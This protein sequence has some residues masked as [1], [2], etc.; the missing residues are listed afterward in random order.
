MVAPRPT[1]KVL[2]DLKTTIMRPALTSHFQ[3]W[4]NPPEAMRTWARTHRI[5][6]G[7]GDG[8]DSPQSAEFFSLSCAEAT[9]PGSSLATHEINNDFTGVTERH[10]YR[11]QFDDRS[12]FTFY[13]DK[14]YNIIYFFENWIAYCLNEK[15]LDA[16]GAQDTRVQQSYYSYRANYPTD[17]TTEVFVKKFERDYSGRYLQYSLLKAFPISIS[18]MPVTYDTSEILKC[19]VAFT[20]S[21]YLVSAENA[22]EDSSPSDP[23]MSIL[24]VMPPVIPFS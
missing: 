3:C 2:S 18:S 16:S 24:P 14:D 21:R 10:A 15:Y 4:F 7:F 5:A 9:L 11:R 12:N 19:T 17:Y 22:L 13:V 23:P 20:Y 8:Y 1:K 6:E